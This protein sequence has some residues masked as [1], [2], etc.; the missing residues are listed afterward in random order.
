[1]KKILILFSLV[2][3][4]S[5]KKLAQKC[6]ETFPPIIETKIDTT[7]VVD[8]I[9]LLERD[10]MLYDTTIYIR[11][12][13]SIESTAK[14]E[15]ERKRNRK[16]IDSLIKYDMSIILDLNRQ[17]DKMA[18][19]TFK[20][21]KTIDKKDIEINKLKTKLKKHNKYFLIFIGI[22]ILLVFRFIYKFKWFKLLPF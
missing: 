11:E 15:V 16:S 13:K 22:G 6:L 14:L 20:L 18:Q 1:M 3:C 9:H 5:E 17:L 7:L 4:I 8:T 2:G 10:T 21:K 12:V 19:D